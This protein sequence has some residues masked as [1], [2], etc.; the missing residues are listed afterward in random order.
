[1]DYRASIPVVAATMIAALVY[2]FL[3]DFLFGFGPSAASRLESFAAADRRG[4][5]DKLGDSLVDRLG[6]SLDSWKH[7][8]KWAQLGGYYRGKTVG[9]VVGQSILFAGAGLSAMVIFQNFS[10]TLL[11]AVLLAAYYPIMSL[12]GDAEKVQD[13]VKRALPEAAALIA[14]EMSAGGS[15][16]AAITRA[17][18]IPGSLGA[19]IKN[20]VD[21]ANQSG[22][23]LFS[24]TNVVG[25][26]LTHMEAYQMSQLDAFASQVDMVA[27]RGADG[28]KQMAEVVRGLAREYRMDV[29]R[30]A[31]ELDGKLLMPITLFFFVPFMAAVFIPLVVSILQVL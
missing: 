4:V 27:A 2:W 8:L 18:S 29:S 25:I 30:A 15:A 20:A 23:L 17:A 6:L 21:E 1:M 26:L 22:R 31:E 28:P 9:S 16:E 7:A 12:K 19:M 11:G 14:A 13:D 5:T 3:N 10:P 24:R